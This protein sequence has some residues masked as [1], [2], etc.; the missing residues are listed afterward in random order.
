VEGF[1]N[2]PS[3]CK[4][5]GWFIDYTPFESFAG[6]WNSDE[7]IA[8]VGIGTVVLHVEKSPELSGPDGNGQL[9]LHNVLHCPS[10]FCNIIGYTANFPAKHSV[11]LVPDHTEKSKGIIED[12]GGRPV[13]YFAPN[14]ALYLVKLSE[15]P[16]G[17]AIGPSVI[18]EHGMYQ[19]N[20]R[21]SES[22][23]S[24]WKGYL[25][26]LISSLSAMSQS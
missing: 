13:A 22:E 7:K 9:V 23:Q 20:L 21:W 14:K 10:L 4:D 17:P 16:F 19:I 24:R 18:G 11:I 15:P 6:S 26:S 12:E 3:A 8:V 25:Q 1:A 5:R 2:R